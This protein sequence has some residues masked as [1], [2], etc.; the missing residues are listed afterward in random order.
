MPK[1]RV[2]GYWQYPAPPEFA[3]HIIE[4]TGLNTRDQ[5][6]CWAL[7]DPYH[8]G[9]TEYYAMRADLN[10]KQYSERCDHIFR[11]VMPE[12]IRLAIL[13]WKSERGQL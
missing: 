1:Q 6:I 3:K 10:R 4:D 7:R 11:T 8:C 12:I 13:G 5:E 9:D 2:V